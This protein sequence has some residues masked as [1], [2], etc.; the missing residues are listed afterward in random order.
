VG[1]ARH[2]I[3]GGRDRRNGAPIPTGARS[4][5]A[6]VGRAAILTSLR[7]DT[8]VVGGFSTSGGVRASAADVVSL[9]DA[10]THLRGEDPRG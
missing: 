7:V 8:A 3:S 9:R 2:T 1:W 4:A 5:V 10:L 6:G